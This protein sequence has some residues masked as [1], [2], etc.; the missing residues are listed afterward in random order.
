MKYITLALAALIFCMTFQALASHV[1]KPKLA[2]PALVSN[3]PPIVITEITDSK[4][5]KWVPDGKGGWK[6]K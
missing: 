4:G 3:V 5:H 1:H 6:K 2:P